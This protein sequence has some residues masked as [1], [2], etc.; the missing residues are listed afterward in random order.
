V[1]NV[2]RRPPTSSKTLMGCGK[3][4]NQTDITPIVLMTTCLPVHHPQTWA[5]DII[6]T[7]FSQNLQCG[8]ENIWRKVV[9]I[10]YLDNVSSNILQIFGSVLADVPAKIPKWLRWGWMS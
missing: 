4:K 3:I 1:P 8:W 10:Y 7:H 9:H 2:A 6:C 5:D